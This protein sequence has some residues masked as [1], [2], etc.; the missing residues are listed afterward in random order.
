MTK[1]ICKDNKPLYPQPDDY[2]LL[3]NA[4]GNVLMSDGCVCSDLTES[5]ASVVEIN[6]DFSDN[7]EFGKY[8]FI[9]NE[10][11]EV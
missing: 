9:N 6:I 11:I 8:Q 7:F 5:N 10:F 3:Y 4:D 1:Y 2:V